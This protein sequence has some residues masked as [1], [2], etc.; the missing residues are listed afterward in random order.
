MDA[1]GQIVHVLNRGNAR[2]TVFPGDD[3]YRD[4]LRLLEET[5]A[6]HGVALLG[7]CLMPNHFH[8]VARAAR[9]GGLGR[10]MQQLMTAQ[11]R[12]H[13]ARHGGS[14]H[15]WQGRFKAF[16]IQADE[17]YV[18]VLR[19]VERNALR[20]R[21]VRR[22]EAWPWSSLAARAREAGRAPAGVAP[23]PAVSPVPL[24]ADWTARV[25]AAETAAELE[26][27]RR[28]AQRGTPYGGAAWVARTAERLGLEH[29]LRPP[30][31]PRKS[32]APDADRASAGGSGGNE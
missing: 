28:S 30:G 21:L 10:W 14:G 25:N 22:A 24:P 2:Q 32:P 4:F 5:A 12:R 27:I 1:A 18:S 8:L 11:V 19:Y 13:R 23:R 29:T 6:A 9:E 7:W 17:H 15:L 31:R 16:P 3:D 26:A 20:A